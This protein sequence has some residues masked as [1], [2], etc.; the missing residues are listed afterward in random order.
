MG[1]FPATSGSSACLHSLQTPP[2]ADELAYG[3]VQAYLDGGTPE[4][5]GFAVDINVDCTG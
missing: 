4:V 3:V 1:R 5:G 2:R